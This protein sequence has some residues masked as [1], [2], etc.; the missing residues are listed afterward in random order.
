LRFHEIGFAVRSARVA[1]GWTQTDLARAAGL[2]RITVNQLENG[3]CTDLGLRKALAVLAALGLELQIRGARQREDPI[4]A[5]CALTKL[6]EAE[7]VHALLTG[8]VRPQVRPRLRKLLK[9]PPALWRAL[10]EELGKS[11]ERGLFADNAQTF[12]V[13]LES[14]GRARA[15]GSASLF[16]RALAARSARRRR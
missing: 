8:K 6:S 16:L 9:A 4:A 15:T 5:A 14:A 1:R 10:A 12:A 3:V 11:A 7:L 2:S 13:L